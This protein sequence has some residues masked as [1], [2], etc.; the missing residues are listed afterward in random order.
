MNSHSKAFF[1]LTFILILVTIAIPF[2]SYGFDPFVKRSVEN[3]NLDPSDELLIHDSAVNKQVLDVYFIITI[4]QGP[5]LNLFYQQASD[6]PVLDEIHMII[7]FESNNSFKLSLDSVTFLKLNNTSDNVVSGSF[8]LQFKL[9]K[10]S[11]N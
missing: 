8:E 6:T 7:S 5:S 3:F 1:V 10:N 4:N 2:Y 9:L 11:F